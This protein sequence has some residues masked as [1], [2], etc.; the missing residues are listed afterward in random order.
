MPPTLNQL[1]I[2]YC[3]SNDVDS[4]KEL[5]KKNVNIHYNNEEGFILACQYG[6]IEIVRFITT[7]YRT[8]PQY[9]RINIHMNNEA[10]FKYACAYGRLNIVK[11]LTRL[12]KY[13]DYRKINIHSGEEC[14]FRNALKFHHFHIINYLIILSKR[15]KQYKPINIDKIKNH[16]NI[17]HSNMTVCYIINIG[18]TKL[19]QFGEVSPT[20]ERIKN[21]KLLIL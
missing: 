18:L 13:E 16:N 11:Y 9:D 3:S 6:N 12:Y 2:N 4:M 1:F 20:R 14:G 17:L 10:A 21:I 5:L 7:L 15:D 19:T 8:H